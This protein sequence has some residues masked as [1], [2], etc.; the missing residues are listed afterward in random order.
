MAYVKHNIILKSMEVSTDLFDEVFKTWPTRIKVVDDFD[1][2]IK[3][4]R[5]KGYIICNKERTKIIVT[6]SHLNYLRPQEAYAC[7]KQVILITN[8]QLDSNEI[9]TTVTGRS[10][11]RYIEK[12][13][14]KKHSEIEIKR[15]LDA[16]DTKYDRSLIQY[17]EQG[18][19]EGWAQ[20]DN[21]VKY[22]INGAHSDALME[23]FPKSRK[24]L[25]EAYMKRKENP[26]I[27]KYFNFAIG[28]LKR[29]GYDGFYNW[30]VQRTSKKLHEGIE[31]VGGYLLYANTDGFMVMDP[32]NKLDTSSNCGD[33]KL[34]YEGTVYGYS[35]ENEGFTGYWCYQTP[36]EIKG[37]LPTQLRKYVDL[38]NKKVVHFNKT[39]N[40]DSNTFT[41]INIMEETLD[42]H[43]KNFN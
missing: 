5:D 1:N 26:N 43:E 11:W 8:T 30:V 24:D 17:H 42:D 10:A 3:G 14:K 19:V 12:V 23:A 33:F 18:F 31:K 25:M 15:I 41:A 22:D 20:Y 38:P 29:M 37:T 36:N 9:E 6:E 13:L 28:Y 35:E 21:C 27:K 32:V 40:T 39:Y 34:E 7:W 16:F 4:Y 2:Y